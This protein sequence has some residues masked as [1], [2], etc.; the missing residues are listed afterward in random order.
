MAVRAIRIADAAER[1]IELSPELVA[2]LEGQHRDDVAYW[3]EA[4]G[5][6][7]GGAAR[8]TDLDRYMRDVVSRQ[9]EARTVPPL[10]EAWLLER[11][12][13]SL[14]EEALPGAVDQARSMLAGAEYQGSG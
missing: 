4:L 12:S 5:V 1:G 9:V 6:A 13:W 7:E 11:V 14:S 2:E 8:R 3:S 10:F